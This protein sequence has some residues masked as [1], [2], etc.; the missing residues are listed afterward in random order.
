MGRRIIYK[1]DRRGMISFH[2]ELV[3]KANK[4]N[5][6][7]SVADKIPV[8]SETKQAEEVKYEVTLTLSE[9]FWNDEVKRYLFQGLDRM[10]LIQVSETPNVTLETTDLWRITDLFYSNAVEQINIK[11]LK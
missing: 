1:T 10:G 3:N 11:K 8:D 7:N 2:K 5:Y 4:Y 9:K 6:M